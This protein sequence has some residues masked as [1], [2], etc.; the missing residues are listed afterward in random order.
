MNQHAMFLAGIVLQ[1]FGLALLAL[2]VARIHAS[3]RR[4]ERER[5]AVR[6]LA[7][8]L[9]ATPDLELAA[10]LALVDELHRR[11][12]RD[13]AMLVLVRQ[14]IRLHGSARQYRVLGTYHR[15]PRVLLREFLDFIDSLE[16]P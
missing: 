16:N 1:A 4:L 3:R 2:A 14:E 13:A 8:R 10:T 11:H 9:R 15:D 6:D 12:G 5:D 7:A